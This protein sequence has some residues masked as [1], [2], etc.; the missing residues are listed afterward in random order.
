MQMKR[1]R[2]GDEL[3]TSKPIPILNP[4]KCFYYSCLIST[5]TAPVTLPG[6]KDS[7]PISAI[8]GDTLLMMK[9][10]DDLEL[11]R[12][13]TSEQSQD[14]FTTLVQR[15][16]NLVYSAGLRQVRSPQLAEEVAQSVFTDLARTA[17]QLKPDTVLTAWLYKVTRRTAINV[18]RGE[19]RRQLREQIAVEMNAMNATADDWMQIEPILDE[20]MLALDE[21][22]RI[23]VLLRYFENKSL[24]EVGETL[25]TSDDTARKRVNRAV[26]RLREFFAKRG[27]TVGAN[28]L[29]MVISANAVQA[30][31]SGLAATIYTASAL[32]GTNLAA[33]ATVSFTK[34]IAMTTVQKAAIAVALVVAVGTGIYEAN[35]A[36]TLRSQVQSL[37]QQT[38]QQ[39]DRIDLSQREH[40]DATQRIATLDGEN[41][42][43]KRNADELLKLRAEVA[44]LRRQND[45]QRTQTAGKI[46]P[47]PGKSQEVD[48]AWVQQIL[49][50][51][52]KDQGAVAGILR[53]KLL[54]QEMT[55]ISSSEMALRSALLQRKLNETLE[56]SPGAF[57]DFQSAY[58]QAALAISDET[59]A[60][61]IRD[62]IQST[63]E[64][65]VAGGLDIPSKPANETEAWVQ[66]RHQLDREATARLKQLFTPEEQALFDRAFL[67][68]MGVDLGGIGVDKSNYPKGFLSPVGSP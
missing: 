9:S 64:Q 16:L 63:Y 29:T 32:A 39:S 62:L 41:D 65:A 42:R 10:T 20:A 31:P 14:A 17:A 27:V 4:A 60:Q 28:G 44:R 58:I 50:S 45:A 5:E 59:K 51:P 1:H 43:L 37:I 13:F 12:K 33:T 11:L 26:E 54:R 7:F 23:A 18:V 68:V 6:C 24:R 38:T 56:R 61:Q 25:G 49:D 15:H 48:P 35:R 66:Q 2:T 52:P 53:G 3:Y 40:D 55:N 36:S 19:A 34:A 67:G 21:A 8:R 30:A 46:A 47:P 57:A 22:D